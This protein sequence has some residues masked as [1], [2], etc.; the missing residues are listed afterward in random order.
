MLRDLT[1]RVEI[2]WVNLGCVSTRT[3]L[4]TPLRLDPY[5]DGR[6]AHQQYTTHRSFQRLFNSN[7]QRAQTHDA[8]FRFSLL[9][10]LLPYTLHSG[11]FEGTSMGRYWCDVDFISRAQDVGAIHIVQTP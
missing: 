10:P 8:E 2:V 1:L 7:V 9:H 11:M 5:E 3:F 6:G 4:H